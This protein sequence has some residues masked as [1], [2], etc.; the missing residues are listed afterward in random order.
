MHTL[1]DIRGGEAKETESD[2]F[3]IAI[4][5]FVKQIRQLAH[6]QIDRICFERTCTLLRGHLLEVSVDFAAHVTFLGSMELGFLSD[7][8]QCDTCQ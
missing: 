6:E 8:I 1:A 7:L 4:V 5:Q 2:D 3:P